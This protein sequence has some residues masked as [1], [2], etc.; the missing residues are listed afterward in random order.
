M[1]YVNIQPP[2]AEGGERYLI[3][4]ADD[5]GVSRGVNRGIIECHRQGVLTSTSLAVTGRA[6]EEAAALSRENPGLAVGLH[7][8]VWGEGER[9]FD[10]R[11]VAATRDEFHR[12][13]DQF[14]RIMGRTPTHV[15]SHQHAHRLTHLFEHF[16]Q[17]VAPLQVPLRGGGQIRFTGGF[18]AQWQWQ[19]TDL[20]HV[21]VPF[22]Q[23]MLRKEVLPG[24][25]EFSCHPG[26]VSDDYRAVYYHEREAELT[27]LID[28]RV[29]GTVEELGIRLI[30]YAEYVRLKR[31]AA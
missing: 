26:Y 21:S 24:F 1:R 23:E 30:S 19:V 15:D 4:N 27:T 31:G 11:D 7:F 13:L 22:L 12:Q 2:P 6:V 9:Q 18:Y 8:D 14:H 28:P 25:T 29:R 3:F 16:R 5:F 20:Y 10:I 17:W